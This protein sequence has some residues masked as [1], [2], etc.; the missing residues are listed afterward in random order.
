M[1]WNPHQNLGSSLLP[2]RGA[3]KPVH[4]FDNADARTDRPPPG[5]ISISLRYELSW[6]TITTSV[7]HACAPFDDATK[8]GSTRR[9][10][11]LSL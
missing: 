7:R 8:P 5:P 11:P 1:L 4:A 6:L 9:L 10:R 2:G 3:E